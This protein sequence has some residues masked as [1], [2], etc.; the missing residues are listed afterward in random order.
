MGTIA[1]ISSFT[2]MKNG[3]VSKRTANINLKRISIYL[4]LRIPN[5]IGK[6]TLLENR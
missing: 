3:H 2:T 1:E 5:G 6:S 4:L